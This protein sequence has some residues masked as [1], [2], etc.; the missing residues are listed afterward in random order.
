MPAGRPT[1]LTPD[2]QAIILRRIRA[3][4]YRHVAAAAAGVHRNTL[5]NWE[6]WGEEGREPYAG[7]LCA[8]QKAEADAEARAL[9]RVRMGGDGWQSMAWWLERRHAT[10]WAA[11][12]RQHVAE[13][14][15]NIATKLRADPEVAAKVI[16]AA[17]EDAA[18]SA[19]DAKH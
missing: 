19:A 18:G 5:I 2:V 1:S 14:L 12:V 3:G 16:D 11:R 4:N 17:R 6:R 7:F 10:R 13:E 8:M 9:R 15:G